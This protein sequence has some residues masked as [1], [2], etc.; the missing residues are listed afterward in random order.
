MILLVQPVVNTN[1]FFD[2]IWTA[3]LL[4]NGAS[5]YINFL[6]P[7]VLSMRLLR[8]YILKYLTE[9]CILSLGR[10]FNFFFLYPDIKITYGELSL[11][12]LDCLCAI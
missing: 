8:I 4:N 1:C 3:S 10:L 7:S 9:F 11:C 2:R 6:H 12:S 5:G